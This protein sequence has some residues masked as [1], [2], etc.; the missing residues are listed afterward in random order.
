MGH[1]GAIL[2]QARINAGL[3]QHEVALRIDVQ[4]V[5][6]SRW[7]RGVESPRADRLAKLVELYRLDPGLVLRALAADSAARAQRVQSRRTS[8]G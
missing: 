5:Y 7:E 2:R 3:T 6:L 1:L 4:D 8:R